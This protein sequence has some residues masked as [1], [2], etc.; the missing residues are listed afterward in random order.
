M[1]YMSPSIFIMFMI[2]D[3]LFTVSYAYQS[4]LNFGIL[5]V[6]T[7]IVFIIG[8]MIPVFVSRS[9]FISGSCLC[10]KG[11]CDVAVLLPLLNRDSFGSFTIVIGSVCLSTFTSLL[12]LT[13]VNVFHSTDSLS[14]PTNPPYHPFPQ[15]FLNFLPISLP[16]LLSYSSIYHFPDINF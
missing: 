7:L 16:I 4:S 2:V 12:L 6:R 13:P 3:P 5:S 11:F 14:S 10:L 15:L 9:P 1:I 8:T